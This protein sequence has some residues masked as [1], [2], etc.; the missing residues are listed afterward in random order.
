MKTVLVV[1]DNVGVAEYIRD[2]FE[3]RGYAVRVAHDGEDGWQELQEEIPDVIISDLEMPELNGFEL[4]QRVRDYKPTETLPFIM[5]TARSERENIRHGM[6]SGADD[7]LTKPFAANEILASVETMLGK[8]AKHQEKKRKTLDILRKN[9]TYAL[10]HELRTPLQSVLGYANMMQM[11]SEVLTPE[12]ISMMADMIFKAGMRLQRMTE[13][14]LTYAQIEI[15][16]SDPEQKAQLR[17]HILHDPAN[18]IEKTAE[19]VAEEYDRLGD[20]QLYFDHQVIQMSSEN[21]ECIIRELLS[22]AFKF[23]DAGTPVEIHTNVSDTHYNIEI[24]DQGRGM[25][26]EQIHLIGPYM[27]F[28]RIIYEQQGMGMGLT[29]AK[30]LVELHEGVFKINS[31]PN[32]GTCILVQL[33]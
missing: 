16:S 19:N 22:N 30:R 5:L 33:T 27:Q 31:R 24:C 10:P 1:E 4:L 18:V 13:N 7:Y 17:N 20:L 21:L 8:H 14:A 32:E 3:V 28:D 23:S 9:I 25:D 6:N 26:L 11:D 15:I 29:I 2:I 12:Q